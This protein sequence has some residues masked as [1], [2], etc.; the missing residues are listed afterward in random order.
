MSAP[1]TSD[2]RAAPADSQGELGRL[3]ELRIRGLGSID[4][5]TLELGRG[6]T[7]VTGETGAG[8]TMVVTG[9]TL[10]FGGRADPGRVRAAGRAGVEGRLVLPADSPAWERAADAGAD[11][12]DDGSLILAR[13]VSAEGRSRAFLGGLG[14]LACLAAAA[15]E[16]GGELAPPLVGGAVAVEEFEVRLAGVPVERATLL[17][18]PG[19]PQLIGLTV[20]REQPLGELG[21]HA[22]RDAAAAEERPGPAFGAHRAGEDEAAVVVGVGAGVGGALPRG[23]FG[24]QDEPS[25]H[26]GTPGGAD[27][28]GVGP[29]TEE[30]GQAGHDHGLAGAGLPRDDR[31]PTAQLEGDVVDRSQPSDAQL[32]QSPEAPG[33]VAVRGRPQV[34]RRRS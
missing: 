22:H 7:V 8:K 33:F 30:Q 15:L 32:G 31:E 14:Q 26:A 21:D 27:P 23:G 6:L 12:D 4:D 17:G 10:L 5:V 3:T 1:T 29:T 2:R 34:T 16:V 25:L 20:H 13:T 11:P 18:R 9:L 19:Q 28:A 24:G